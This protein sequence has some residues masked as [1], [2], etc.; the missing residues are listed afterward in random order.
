MMAGRFALAIPVLALAGA[1]A[2]QGRRVLTVGTLPTDSFSFGVFV[3]GTAIIVGALS[4]FPALAL[5]PILEHLTL[6]R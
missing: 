3:A 4:Y 1:F 6:Y 5:G 2:R